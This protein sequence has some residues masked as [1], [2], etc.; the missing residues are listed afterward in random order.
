M[1]EWSTSRSPTLL[2]HSLFFLLSLVLWYF[3]DN[4]EN[5]CNREAVYFFHLLLFILFTLFSFPIS[6][7]PWYCITVLPHFL[8]LTL[9]WSNGK[10][11]WVKREKLMWFRL[12]WKL[13]SWF[14]I[15]F[16]WLYFE[17]LTFSLSL[18]SSPSLFFLTI[19]FFL[20]NAIFAL[21]FHQ[22]HYPEA[23]WMT[24]FS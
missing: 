24:F 13:P 22:S 4:I 8:P 19:P 10:L 12:N 14:P 5:Q 18:S 7:F 23:E 3:N 9:H 15:T 16:Y 11:N 21:F 2:T 6:L 17:C 1:S 20:C